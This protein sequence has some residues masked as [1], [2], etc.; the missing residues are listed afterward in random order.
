[1]DSLSIK[2]QKCLFNGDLQEEIY[3]EQ[4]FFVQGGVFWFGMLPS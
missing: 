3:I 4:G 1:M 2:F